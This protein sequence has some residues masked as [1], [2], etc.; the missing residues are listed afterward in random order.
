MPVAIRSISPTASCLRVERRVDGTTPEVQQMRFAYTACLV[1]FA[2][3]ARAEDPSALR[4]EP[5]T[6]DSS[7]TSLTITLPDPHGR[8]L[9]VTTPTGFFYLAWDEGAHIEE[10]T[11]RITDFAHARTLSL[12]PRTLEGW[13]FALSNPGW[14]RIFASTGEYTFVT[15]DVLQ[16]D[17]TP[18]DAIPVSRC[19]V[20][21]R[22]AEDA[23]AS[24]VPPHRDVA[25]RMSAR[26]PDGA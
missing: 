21:Y 11:P 19:R 13:H 2:S 16:T 6:L 25:G 23:G 10:A 3:L 24:L 14:Q 9:G 7:S 1:L 22:G 15:G 8:E 5:A 17:T 18:A 12:D 20:R 26:R 4:C